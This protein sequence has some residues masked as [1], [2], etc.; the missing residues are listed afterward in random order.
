MIVLF[1][2]RNQPFTLNLND[3]TSKHVM[4]GEKFQLTLN[5]YQSEDVQIHIKLKDFIVVKMDKE[6]G[7]K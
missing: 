7:N 6:G 5:Q 4:G 3:N 2:K 1:N